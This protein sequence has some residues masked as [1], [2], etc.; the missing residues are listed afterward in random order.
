MLHRFQTMDTK[1]LWLIAFASAAVVVFTGFALG[2]FLDDYFLILMIEG[3]IP[4]GAWY[5][6]FSFGDGNPATASLNMNMGPFPWFVFPEFKAHFFRPFTC[7]TMAFDHWA[8]GRTAAL[9]HLHSLGWY[10]AA[11]LAM[12]LILRRALPGRLALLA[13]ILFA[14]DEGHWGSAVWWANRNALVAAVPALY[15]LYAHIRWRED[16]WKPGLPLSMLGYAVGLCG[17]ETAV[18]VLAYLA[19]YELFRPLPADSSP[20]KGMPGRVIALFPSFFIGIIYVLV[21]KW[22]NYGAYGS[23]IYIDPVGNPLELLS[24]LPERLLLLLVTHFFMLPVELPG[25][26]PATA[27]PL[28]VI[29]IPLVAL[30][31]WALWKIWPSLS[32]EERGS[33]RWLF[34]GAALSMLPVCCTFPSGRL[35]LV[36]SVG[37]AAAIAVLIRAG[38]NSGMAEGRW[39]KNL[40]R[41]LVVIHLVISPLMWPVQTF[42]IRGFSN[43]TFHSMRAMDIHPSEK[44]DQEVVLLN[45]GHPFLGAYP[46]IFRMYFELPMPAYIRALAMVPYDIRVTRTAPDTLEVEVIDG[47][48]FTTLFEQL[49][50]DA[51]H[52]MRA[53]DVVKIVGMQVTVLEAGPQGP[54][55][56]SCQFAHPLEDPRYAFFIVDNN[57]YKKV[58]LPPVGESALFPYR[59]SIFDF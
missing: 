6:L 28:I 41:A 25:V 39:R 12:G 7:L 58:A 32:R 9:Y 34:A 55:R 33:L 42:M 19:A 51:R 21:Y 40:A 17:G 57:A 31:F 52:P 23:G 50:R 22:G 20:L 36:P 27:L 46:M 53:G 47:E 43:N 15:G 5:D 3:K 10:L 30:I 18:S 44:K 24:W 35:M 13:L 14:V 16:G 37:G 54:K 45:S 11:V 29:S 56:F 8:F 1:W 4:F 59:L 26:F 38:W 2:F 48:M 49:C